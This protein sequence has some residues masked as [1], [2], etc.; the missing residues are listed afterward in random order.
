MNYTNS[1]YGWDI[2]LV[3][4]RIYQQPHLRAAGHPYFINRE[5]MQ[6]SVI[7]NGQQFTGI[8]LQ[9]DIFGD[10]LIYIHRSADGSVNLLQLNKEQVSGFT[11]K[12][13]RFITLDKERIAGLDY[14]QY[15]EALVLDNVCLLNKWEKKFEQG[16]VEDF[17]YGRFLSENKSTFILRQ[18]LLVKIK[19]RPSL[20]KC[21]ED[22]KPELKQY[23]KANKLMNF[24][25]K[26]HELK[27][28]IEFYNNIL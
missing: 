18:G 2:R 3:N 13:H 8:Q 23:M 24:F 4:G 14:P 27:A 6:G 16:K 17:P 19:N 9:Y 21:L 1:V 28:I 15:F 26:D 7:A 5:W 20:L 10:N 11:I 12:S 25:L 22:K